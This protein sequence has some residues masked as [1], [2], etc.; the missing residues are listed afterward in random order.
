MRALPPDSRP[1]AWSA[2]RSSPNGYDMLMVM[3]AIQ[4]LARPADAL[5]E[6]RRHAN[7]MNLGTAG[8]FLVLESREHA[9]ARGAHIY[10]RL[11]AV[12]GDRGSREGE[13]MNSALPACADETGASDGQ[14]TRW[15]FAAQAA[16]PDLSGRERAFLKSRFPSAPVRTVRCI[17]RPFHRSPFHHRLALA[18]LAL[19]DDAQIKPMAPGAGED[20]P[21]RQP[22]RLI[23]TTIGHF[24][25]EGIAR[26]SRRQS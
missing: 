23:V 6:Q 11:D 24:R 12:L 8:A 7:G 15:C 18:C 14:P 25:G 22:N 13:R 26:L 17:V 2:A 21:A 16:F 5:L 9:E 20:A 4:G 3:E 19:D 1:I 10:A